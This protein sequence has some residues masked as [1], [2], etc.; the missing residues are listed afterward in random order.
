MEKYIK[1]EWPEIQDYMD[2]P[3]YPE[4]CY[5]DP[6]KN[7]WFIPEDW[8]PDEYYEEPEPGTKEYFDLHDCW[9][10]IGGDWQG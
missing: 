2:N 9:D 6:Q 4:V 10:A 7:C 5:F 1:V 3:D 8:E